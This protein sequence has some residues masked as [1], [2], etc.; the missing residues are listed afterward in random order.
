MCG[1]ANLAIISQGIDLLGSD[2]Q[3]WELSVGE[4]STYYHSQPF[5]PTQP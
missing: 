4:A 2:S 5:L 1:L 3:T